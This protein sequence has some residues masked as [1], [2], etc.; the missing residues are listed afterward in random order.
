MHDIFASLVEFAKRTWAALLLASVGIIEPVDVAK[1]FGFIN[2]SYEP[3]INPD[4]VRVAFIVALLGSLFWWFH[5]ERSAMASVNR[6]PD[7][8]LEDALGYIATGRW[9]AIS[10]EGAL[11]AALKDFRQKIA[12]KAVTCWGRPIGRPWATIDPISD[13]DWRKGRVDL[14]AIEFE[15]VAVNAAAHSPNF[16]ALHVCRAEVE[17]AWPRSLWQRLRGK[18]LL[19]A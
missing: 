8:R 6:S 10:D 7:T 12:E 2:P 11:N 13:K 18:A 1:Q 17:R 15:L 5:K 16:T 9:R 19:P 14:L 3:P 4:I